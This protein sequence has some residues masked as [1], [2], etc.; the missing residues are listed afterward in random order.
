MN[1]ASF[2]AGNLCK[3]LMF[4]PLEASLETAVDFLG[5]DVATVVLVTPILWALQRFRCSLAVGV[6]C[7]H[8]QAA[9]LVPWG[10]DTSFS[11]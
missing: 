4:R 7:P 3:P 5:E 11:R 8:F 9:Q 6:N 1:R 2:E 10:P